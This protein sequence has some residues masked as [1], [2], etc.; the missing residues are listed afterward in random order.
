MFKGLWEEAEPRTEVYQEI[1]KS[2][3]DSVMNMQVT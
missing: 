1:L 2:L 3:V